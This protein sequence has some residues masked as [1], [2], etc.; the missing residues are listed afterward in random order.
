MP[1]SFEPSTSELLERERKLRAEILRR[2][3]APRARV[4]N[5][6]YDLHRGIEAPPPARNV[7]EPVSDLNP[8]TAHLLYVDCVSG[9][10]VTTFGRFQLSEMERAQV[11]YV[12]MEPV[13]R[14]M[15]SVLDAMAANNGVPQL[16]KMVEKQLENAV[17]EAAAAAIPPP[18]PIEPETPIPVGDDIDEEKDLPPIP[19]NR[20]RGKKSR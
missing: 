19:L 13:K 4:P 16:E 15:N 3:E 5:N 1:Q 12:A 18:L 6:T 17:K 11:A 2:D 14:T 7:E 20:R 9:R 8:E 10:V